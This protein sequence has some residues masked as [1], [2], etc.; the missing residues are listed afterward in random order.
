MLKTRLS[1]MAASEN[2][3]RQFRRFGRTDVEPIAVVDDTLQPPRLFGFVIQLRQSE[4]SVGR[5]VK[6]SRAQDLRSRENVRR[7][8]FS[9][10]AA[11]GLSVFDEIISRAVVSVNARNRLKHQNGIRR[12]GIPRL[13]Q[14]FQ[15]GLGR[16]RPQR[17]RIQ[18]KKRLIP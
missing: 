7:G 5:T 15:S 6:Q 3:F 13:F 17:I 4:L 9:R 2:L 10:D 14:T 12:F 8:C 1:E 16:F 18:N 11:A